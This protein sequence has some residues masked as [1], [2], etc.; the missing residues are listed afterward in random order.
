MFEPKPDGY[1]SHHMVFKFRGT[2]PEEVYDGRRV[3]I[4]I[5]TALQ[6]SWATAV[7]AVG[8]FRRE[9][10][11]AG[12]GDAD[13]LRLFALMSSE[14]AMEEHCAEAD[15]DGHRERIREIVELDLNLDAVDTLERLSQAFEYTDKYQFDPR[16][17]PDY[18]KIIYN[19]ETAKVRVEPLF[20]A[21]DATQSY[22]SSE[23]SNAESGNRDVKIVLVEVDEIENL[24]TAYPIA[25]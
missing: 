14:F 15:T 13:W 12:K 9:D 10:M 23:V 1:R 22:D 3:E 17:E 5:R 8:L 2:G 4:Q 6:H 11:K 18:F 7:E 16:N 21:R 24:K 19:R 20:G 25:L